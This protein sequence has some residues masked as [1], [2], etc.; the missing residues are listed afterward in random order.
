M[1]TV[2]RSAWRWITHRRCC[3]WVKLRTTAPAR[4][5][6]K[7]ENPALRSWTWWV[8]IPSSPA[9]PPFPLSFTYLV[10]RVNLYSH[11]SPVC[12]TSASSA[13]TTS[14]LS[15][16]RWAPRG[17]SC[18]RRIP[19]KLP[20]GWRGSAVATVAWGGV[21]VKTA[22]TT[23]ACHQPPAPH[24]CEC[25]FVTKR[26]SSPQFMNLFIVFDEYLIIRWS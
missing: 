14:K 3:C 15:I 18:S 26:Y 5:W 2:C 1:L 23:A 22:S 12:S 8:W 24:H 10:Q 19:E 6:K 17:P 11:Y 7:T 25:M 9:A 20:T 4:P 21:C 13:S 16:R